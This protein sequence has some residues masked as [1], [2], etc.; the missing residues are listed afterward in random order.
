MSADSYSGIRTPTLRR[1]TRDEIP[2]IESLLQAA[3]LP[4][5]DLDSLAADSFL[6]AVDDDEILGLIGLE[7]VDRIGLLRSL[8]VAPAARKLGLGGKLVGA[9]EAAAETAGLDSLWLLTTDADEF[10]RRRGYLKVSRDTAPTGVQNTTEFADLCPQDAHLMV[11]KL[12]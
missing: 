2:V 3:D 9:L 5:D 7:I 8:V 6:V 12:S 1:A 10:F 11:K 4:I